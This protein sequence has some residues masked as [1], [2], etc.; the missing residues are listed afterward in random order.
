MKPQAIKWY[1]DGSLTDEGSGLGVVGPTLK[2]YESMGRYTSI[3]QAEVCAIVRCAEFNLQRN[4][5]GRDIA[6]LSDSQAAIKALSKAKITSKV[7][8]KVRTALDKLGAVNK[9]TI[10]WV[11]GHNNIPGNELADNL[12]RK[13][14]KKPSNWARAL[15]SCWSP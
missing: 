4:Y 5:R 9:P 14:A 13:E 15:L 3:F 6:I 12:A 10:R 2:Y 8:S 7:V 11:P 1:T